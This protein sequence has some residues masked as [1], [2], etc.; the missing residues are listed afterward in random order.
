MYRYVGATEIR[1]LM[2]GVSRQRVY[3]LTKHKDF[4]APAAALAQGKVWVAEEVEAWIARRHAT[5]QPA[6]RRVRKKE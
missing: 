4:P 6:R 2:H 3:Q 5:G 1:G